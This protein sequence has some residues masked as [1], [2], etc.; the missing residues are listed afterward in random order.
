MWRTRRIDGAPDLV[1]SSVVRVLLPLVAFLAA[2]APAAAAHWP[3]QGG[4]AGRSGYQS[5]GDGS[6]PV[7]PLWAVGANVVAGPL[8]TAGPLADQRVVYGTADGRV[9]LRDLATGRL[10]GPEGGVAVEDTLTAGVFGDPS[11]G[12]AAAFAES[13]GPGGLGMVFAVHNADNRQPVFGGLDDVEVAVIDEA[14]GGVVQD[15]PVRGT[16]DHRVN[17]PAVLSPPEADGGRSLLFLTQA[18]GGEVQ[19]VRVPID[20]VGR[21]GDAN[22]VGVPGADPRAGAAIAYLPVGGRVR[23]FAAVGAGDGVLTFSL[24]RF[25]E[26]G[27]RGGL[28]PGGYGT[29]A[30][31]VAT[32]GL[33]P[34]QAGSS[35]AAAPGIDVLGGEAGAVRVHRLELRDGA[36][37]PAASSDP[38]P[39]VRA[40]GL[41]VAQ[42]VVGGQ[43]APG[44][45]LA[46]T[47]E[48]L[49]VLDARTLRG[50]GRIDGESF[51][52][53]VASGAG[54]VGYA[55]GDDGAPLAID[56]PRG[57]ALPPP[58][59]T[60]DPGHGAAT[61]P[62]GQPAI[63]RGFVIFTT[64]AGVF[65]Y[66]TRCGNAIAGTPGND[67]LQAG[68]PGDAISGGD[69][70]DALGG[71]D[72]D[73]CLDGGPGRDRVRGDA[74]DDT[75]G[76]AEGRD[77][78]VGGP[79]S[80][81]LTGG[82]GAD[83]LDGGA[84]DDVL[85]GGDGADML[86]GG[87]GR[88]RLAGGRGS[89]R[90]DGGAGADAINARGGGR[91]RIRCGP[92]RDE[93]LADR[94]DRV[95]GDC[96]RVLR[97]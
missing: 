17:G 40:P 8:V 63:S 26:A 25:P 76:G 68:I 30:V 81:K 50:V 51:A 15:V 21:A 20:A 16:V 54:A 64:D 60:V 22:A 9:H 12:G 77:L 36:L 29:P 18:P 3:Q 58:S 79:G 96:E 24:E 19:L 34:G 70:N 74:G 6:A 49:H 10:R 61:R 83:R 97:R 45:V 11:A 14:S 46:G 43:V 41:A 33:L 67:R 84:D 37:V 75:L 86:L 82:A 73:D 4:D 92:G 71:G 78:A 95:L 94:A 2:A 38:L 1:Q 39:G 89:D 7:R 69:G 80:D 85:L 32:A 47:S 53:S 62:A 90:L 59:F 93:V 65:A 88:D 52:R 23:P 28:P 66:R 35:A 91:D 42:E 56:L 57:R 31:A 44:W 13:S 27:P 72:G 48:G 55:A 87:D 5:V